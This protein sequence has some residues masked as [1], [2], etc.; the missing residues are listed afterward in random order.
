[1]KYLPYKNNWTKQYE[2][3]IK[4]Y[5]LCNETKVLYEKYLTKKSRGRQQT[6][7]EITNVILMVLISEN[8]FEDKNEI[9]D[10]TKYDNSQ[11][12]DIK[13]YKRR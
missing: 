8:I 6:R 12:L 13:I 2:F 3:G 1:M 9:I 5:T 11:K 10:W 4:K 7:T